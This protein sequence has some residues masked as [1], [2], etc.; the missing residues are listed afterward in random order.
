MKPFR[1]KP[2]KPESSKGEIQRVAVVARRGRC[3][4]FTSRVLALAASDPPRYACT[5]LLVGR[6]DPLGVCLRLVV[7]PAP[8][9]SVR[10]R[11]RPT[12]SPDGENVALDRDLFAFGASKARTVIRRSDF[13]PISEPFD[14]WR[15][16]SRTVS[17]TRDVGDAIALGTF[18]TRLETR[19]K[20]S[21]MCASHWDLINLKAK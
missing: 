4:E 8:I 7:E 20:E 19:T 16:I 9:R 18:R 15:R 21:S 12:D 3:D 14:C 5:S 17:N 11:D 6:R 1:G 2:E 10:T 13:A